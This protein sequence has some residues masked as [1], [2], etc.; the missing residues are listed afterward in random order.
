MF[1]LARGVAREGDAWMKCRER[2]DLFR[3]ESV[4]RFLLFVALEMHELRLG[5]RM[6][7]DA[8]DDR[9]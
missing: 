9:I 7:G 2:G 3:S 4:A 1:E 6:A 8:R 5:G